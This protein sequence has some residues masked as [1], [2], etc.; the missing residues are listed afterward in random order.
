M[1]AVMPST[2]RVFFF[3]ALVASFLTVFSQPRPAAAHPHAFVEASVVVVFDRQGLA[4]FRQK[5][6]LD[7]MV[8]A[9]VLELINENGDGALDERERRAVEE[10]SFGSL[11][12][13]NYFTAIKV[14]GQTLDDMRAS[15][16][17]SRLDGKQLVYE[18]FVA[19]PIKAE[20]RPHEA[21]L[22]IYDE[23]FYTY[24]SYA[25]ENSQQ[26]DPTADPL[27]SQPSAEAKPEDFQR[28]S[29]AVGLSGYQGEVAL[30]GPREDLEIE[31]KV[32]EAPDMAYF[33][34]EIIP[35]AF[36]VKL[37]RP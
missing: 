27:F 16:F 2:P 25:G 1:M 22:A 21:E 31:A 26:I 18:F 23:S 5:W 19:C 28:F 9:S 7:P 35:E 20:T 4:G 30:E 34:N 8:S 12:N 15:D 3:A 13:Y 10:M 11:Q 33:Y 17:Q 36:K 14:D 32:A 37:R 24:I 6:V 29:Q